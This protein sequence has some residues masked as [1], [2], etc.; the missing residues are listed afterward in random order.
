MRG[1]VVMNGLI[2][3]RMGMTLRSSRRAVITTMGAAAV[4]AF[5]PLA[6]AGPAGAA[7]GPSSS[8]RSAATVLYNG[9]IFTGEPKCPPAQALAVGRDGRILAVGTNAEVHRFLGRD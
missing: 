4:G 9:V 2:T 1:I 3:Q 8:R 7:A 5:V 6:A